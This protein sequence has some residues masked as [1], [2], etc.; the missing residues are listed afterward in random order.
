MYF[1]ER[2][3]CSWRR[4]NIVHSAFPFSRLLMVDLYMDFRVQT[5]PSVR[6][7]TRIP[8]HETCFSSASHVDSTFLKTKVLSWQIIR[9]ML[10]Y[11]K[12]KIMVA[13]YR[14]SQKGVKYEMFLT[15]VRRDKCVMYRRSCPTLNG[16]AGWS[17]TIVQRIVINAFSK[18]PRSTLS[19]SPS[20]NYMRAR[21]NRWRAMY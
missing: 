16:L 6:I 14:Y 3:H 17:E 18:Q 13:V 1:T 19:S 8:L 10:V 7:V 11:V 5:T 9:V 12:Y 15:L 4:W 2:A 21:Y 20:Q